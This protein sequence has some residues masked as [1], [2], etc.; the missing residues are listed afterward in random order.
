[1]L[2]KFV[3]VNGTAFVGFPLL[4]DQ[5]YVLAPAPVKIAVEPIQIE[6]AETEAV[7]IGKAFTKI[8]VDEVFEQPLASIPV[9]V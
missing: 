7:T 1:M 9:T 2:P 6:S 8:D 5:V 3:G 4:L